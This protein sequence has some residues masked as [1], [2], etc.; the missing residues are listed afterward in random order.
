MGAEK[1][2][3]RA[4]EL[5]RIGKVAEPIVSGLFFL[6]RQGAA[7]GAITGEIGHNNVYINFP[8]GNKTPEKP[9]KG[10]NIPDRE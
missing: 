5:A 2:Q 4:G 7:F 1:L 10:N 9:L 6:N 8:I 3:F